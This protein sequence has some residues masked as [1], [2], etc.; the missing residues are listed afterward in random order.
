MAY[1]E[2]LVDRIREII[3]RTHDEVVE[4]KMF[5][6]LCFMVN[7]KMCVGVMKDQMMVRFNP[8]K[9]EEVMSLEGVSQMNFTGKSM[10]GF[11]FVQIDSLYTDT[12]L[13]YWINLAL[14]FNEI[15]KASTKK[16]KKK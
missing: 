4:K 12:Y 9:T 3:S 16:T 13:L 11:V 5:G 10:N 8:D 15:A 2:I 7:S 14:D 6:G 1:N